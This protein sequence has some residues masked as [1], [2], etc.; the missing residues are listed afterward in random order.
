MLIRFFKAGA[1]AFIG[2][3]QGSGGGKGITSKGH[4]HHS[5]DLEFM[6]MSE[7]LNGAMTVIVSPWQPATQAFIG[8][9]MRSQLGH[10][11]G[12]RSRGIE[13]P[14]SVNRPYLGI[15]ILNSIEC[16][17]SRLRLAGN[18]QWQKGQN[19]H[20]SHDHVFGLSYA[21]RNSPGLINSVFPHPFHDPVHLIHVFGG[22]H[23]IE[24]S[25]R[26]GVPV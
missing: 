14:A 2:V 16:F 7:T 19:E 25:A 15:H 20:Y 11:K 22:F 24:D 13:K 1:I 23:H 17:I 8:V 26:Q 6:K 9:G 12:Q 3:F 21:G 10:A 4:H 18:D 5:P